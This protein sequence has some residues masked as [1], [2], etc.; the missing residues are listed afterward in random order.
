[1]KRGFVRAVVSL[2]P[3]Q[4]DAIRDEAMRRMRARKAGRIDAGEVIRE[5]VDAWIGKRKR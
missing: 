3:A 2:R 4:L 5:A 1:M